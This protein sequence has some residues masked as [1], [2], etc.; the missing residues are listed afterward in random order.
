MSSERE[1]SLTT[2]TVLS[3]TS[4]AALMAA[5]INRTAVISDACVKPFGMWYNL[6]NI[7]L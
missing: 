5:K 2:A 3:T 6:M 4:C 7:P 1:L